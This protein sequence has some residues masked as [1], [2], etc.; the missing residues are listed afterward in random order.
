MGMAEGREQGAGQQSAQYELLKAISEQYREKII[1]YDVVSDTISV[2]NVIDGQFVK[3]CEVRGYVGEQHLGETFVA[4]EDR[5]E[6]RRVFVK[7]LKKPTHMVVDLR[8]A[9][10]GDPMEWNRL[11]L[12]SVAGRG[13]EVLRVGG[14]FVSIH[15]DKLFTEQ[16]RMRAE[17]DALTGVY[18]HVAFEEVCGNALE[19]CDTNA[20]FLMLDVDDFKSINDT[21]GHTVGDMVLRQ[22]GAILNKTVKNCGV[23]GRLGG[24]EFALLVW[25]IDEREM[26]KL[27]SGLRQEL[28]TVIFDTRYSASMGVSATDG[29]T[30][31]FQDLYG[32]ADQAVYAAKNGG[33]DRV[34]FY[35]EMKEDAADSRIDNYETVSFGEV[36]ERSLLAEF[37]KS[38]N[39]LTRESYR[40]GLKKLLD[41]LL[42]YFDADCA[43]LISWE[44]DRYLGIDERHREE[45]AALS[46]IL[47][48]TVKRGGMVQF[49]ELIDAK[50]NVFLKNV[51]EIE[52]SY[53]DICRRLTQSRVWSMAGHEMRMDFV[54]RGILLVMNPRKHLSERLLLRMMAD[55]LVSR[56]MMQ[57]VM[58]KREYETTHDRLTGLWNRNSFILTENAWRNDMYG[59]LGI[60]TTDIVGLSYVNRDFGYLVGSRKLVAIARALQEVF[61]EFRI[62]RYDGDEMLVCCPNVQQPEF[63]SLLT[64]LRGKLKELDFKVALGCSWSRHANLAEQ[65]VEAQLIMGNDKTYLMQSGELRACAEQSVIDEVNRNLREGNYLVYMQPKVNV[66]TKRRWERRRSY[67]RSIRILV[68]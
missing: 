2:Y 8:C 60:V 25:G 41:S 17:I 24:D 11:Y 6:Y 55:Y 47:T 50:G 20:F 48:D 66:H 31:T 44:E 13:K 52:N 43:A 9:L 22:T 19:A 33:K 62:F 51:K 59:P 14:R 42:E 53:P 39:F 21:Q 23:A 54:S 10:A 34:V 45:A 58:E 36:N 49:L 3:E 68:W 1:E 30:V 40:A 26:R 64:E 7:C 38:M 27:C 63:E 15:K 12:V 18:N 37:G 61:A 16:M 4:E 28:K 35:Q 65:L 57:R 67:G 46:R 29:R 5:E 32:E 56:M